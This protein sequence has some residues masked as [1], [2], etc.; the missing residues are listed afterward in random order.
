MHLGIADRDMEA[1]D[2][3][4][5]QV[6]GQAGEIDIFREDHGQQDADAAPG[7]ALRQYDGLHGRAVQVQAR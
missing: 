2:Q 7:L 3:V 1:V 5:G 6:A 4:E